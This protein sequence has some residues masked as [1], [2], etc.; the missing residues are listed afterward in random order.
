MGSGQLMI[1]GITDAD[2]IMI[3]KVKEGSKGLGF[4]PQSLQPAQIQTAP[5]MQASPGYNNCI[6]IWNNPETLKSVYTILHKLL[7]GHDK[8]PA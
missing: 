2:L 6:L 5:N 7:H 4:S 8:E 3:L 1:N